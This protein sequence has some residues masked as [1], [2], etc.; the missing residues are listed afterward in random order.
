[1]SSDP[2]QERRTFPGL[3]RDWPSQRKSQVTRQ[4]LSLCGIEESRHSGDAITR[5]LTQDPTDSF[6]VF[7]AGPKI[8]GVSLE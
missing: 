3:K 2:I 8:Q 4:K 5:V 6:R 1:M 7:S